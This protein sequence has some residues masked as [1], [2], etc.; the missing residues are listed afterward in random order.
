MPRKKKKVEAKAQMKRLPSM[1]VH[2]EAE[3]QA[4]HGS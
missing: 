4:E 1:E 3:L 2:E